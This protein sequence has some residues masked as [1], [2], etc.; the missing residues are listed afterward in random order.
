MY[1]K[2]VSQKVQEN[3]KSR[4]RA[5]G[6]HTSNANET[7]AGGLKPKD[8][9]SR[10]PFIR[11]CSNKS[12]VSNIVISG[13]ELDKLG[14]I[15]F[16]ES[17]Y[18]LGK[19][20]MRPMAGIKDITVDY[21][22]SFKAIREATI[23]WSI[24]SIEDLNRLTPYFL[25]KGKTVVLDW[26]WTYAKDQSL[27]QQFNGSEPFITKNGNGKFE[28]KQQ[29]FTN[30]QKLILEKGGDYDAVGGQVSN[31]E[32]NL[33]ED[34]G[35]DCITKITAMG[36][37]ILEKPIDTG[38]NKA[39]I[40]KPPEGSEEAKATYTPPDSLIN[41]I[42]NLRDIIVYQVFN[43]TVSDKKTEQYRSVTESTQGSWNTDLERH[44]LLADAG[45]KNN[46][47]GYGIS[48]DDK[49]DKRGPNVI[50]AFQKD[51]HEDIFVTWGWFEDQL[52]NRYISFTGGD[53]KNSAK[54][55]IRSIDTVLDEQGLPLVWEKFK[56]A[57]EKDTLTDET[58]EFLQGRYGH[59]KYVARDSNLKNL[60]DVV[61]TPSLI[62]NQPLLYPIDPMKFFTVE[63]LPKSKDVDNL[64]VEAGEV[65]D[66]V[67]VAVVETV[68]NVATKVW[69]FFVGSD[70]TETEA[71]ESN[72]SSQKEPVAISR[73]HKA[74]IDT[75]F[76][77]HIIR[78]KGFADIGNSK[79]GRLRNVWVNIKEIQK[80]FGIKDPNSDDMTEAN[81]NP[82]GTIERSL[83]TLLNSLNTNFHNI[84]DFELG[85]DPFDTTNIRIFDK[86]D[87]EI[88][89]PIYTKFKENSHEVQTLGI[90]RFPSFKIGSIVKSQNLAFK[91][92][93]AQA[94]TILYGSNK[95]KGQGGDSEFNNTQLDKLFGMDN[96]LVYNDKYL[97]DMRTSFIDL[98]E[99]E[100]GKVKFKSVRIG[101][102][103][104]SENSKIVIGSEDGIILPVD[105]KLPSWY[106]R[107]TPGV[108][109]D[110][111]KK[112]LETSEKNPIEKYV[113]QGDQLLYAKEET[114]GSGKFGEA[115]EVEFY[116]F[117]AETKSVTLKKDAAYTLN[118][119]L[120]AASPIAQFDMNSLIPAE[121]TLEV[122]GVGGILPGD[123]IHTDY[124]QHKYK[125]D[126]F[127]QATG[128]KKVRPPVIDRGPLV[129][130]Q[131]FGVS[132]KVDSSGW[133]TEIQ[134][135]MRMNS[136]P[137]ADLLKYESPSN[138]PGKTL[139]TTPE[140]ITKI[141]DPEVPEPT[142]IEV[143]LP[144]AIP[145]LKLRK[146]KTVL[147]DPEYVYQP[148]NPPPTRPSIPLPP[149]EIE[150]LG[151]ET[152][153]ELDFDDDLA[154]WDAPPKPKLPKITPP[155]KLQKT[156]QET[157]TARFPGLNLKY[158]LGNSDQKYKLNRPYSPPLLP[159]IED[160]TEIFFDPK[161]EEKD[162]KV[163]VEKP[164]T[165]T[166]EV[167]EK[168]QKYDVG[169][170]EDPEKVV[171]DLKKKK[172]QEPKPV[173]VQVISKVKIEPLKTTYDPTL[174]WD[175]NP[176]Y[177]LI[178]K[179]VP[180]WY[181]KTKNN[182]KNT[183]F[184]GEGPTNAVFKK[185]R[186]K[187]WD[188]IIEAPNHTGKTKLD[189]T[190]KIQN[191]LKELGNTYKD[192]G[193]YDTWTPITGI[194]SAVDKHGNHVEFPAQP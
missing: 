14:Q 175:K 72:D 50:W 69:N 142:A 143:E 118:S 85:V 107:W 160:K 138:S 73:R 170:W 63:T 2:F 186:Q 17:V 140:V 126:I 58:K 91:I 153:D 139:E 162:K 71:V 181:T 74:F 98:S 151:D 53:D 20:G 80:A 90:Y 121:L 115:S 190:E 157:G 164:K 174:P 158:V 103:K 77:N 12:D 100:D 135:K 187:F 178:Y 149:P 189:T 46:G 83:K 57:V 171:E 119:Y 106:N 92:S 182:P 163:V 125:T 18:K 159:E 192:L 70:E 172:E 13:G 11:M 145:T 136:L 148:N 61:K 155:I 96:D 40:M 109:G 22:G 194:P 120:N 188:E 1:T 114:G 99:S 161:P 113:V 24:S 141:P 66:E 134:T 184:Y 29:I 43:S 9:M 32:Y 28:V 133:S 7:P 59:E 112:K 33:R 94:L 193:P 34:G 177:Q 51:A 62:R 82:R 55:T 47:Q 124:I 122:D 16:G 54:L 60:T 183:N 15:Q 117:D 41:A 105:P 39:N 132:Q 81:I 86:S 89:N 8:I 101:S 6:W 19:T 169:Y 108:G 104:V 42:I 68:T 123:I 88:K 48:V 30:A 176:T 79:A 191:K 102:E 37:S 152:L 52:L 36:S 150:M 128:S 165:Y 97:N 38:G 25:T 179:I 10:T 76:S 87:T 146:V 144:Q 166:K 116:D 111:P 78:R 45:S 129:Y 4:E 26:G 23:N 65:Y 44:N 75:L 5:L 3:L 27:L 31:F 84:W 147:S 167:V 67:V 137:A 64:D 56:D 185:Y 127:S 131:V 168:V 49:E 156:E 173:P 130:F 110:D 35:F 21:K 154:E 93:S 95:P 180:G